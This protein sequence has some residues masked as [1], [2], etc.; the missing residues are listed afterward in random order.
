MTTHSVFGIIW[1]M[2]K[3]T[4]LQRSFVEIYHGMKERN[5]AKAYKQAGSKC[6]GKT[7][8]VEACRTL[9]KPQVRAYLKRLQK[10][11]EERALKTADDIIR[12][13]EKVGFSNIK[14]YFKIE[15]GKVAIKKVSELT[16]AQTAAIAEITQADGSISTFKLYNKLKALKDLGLRFGIFPTKVELSGELTLAQAV[17]KAMKD[18]K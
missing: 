10:K 14:D 8:D 16:E 1:G 13:L 18:E 15:E 11:S 9:K 3:L 2:T 12:E 17:H 6:K 5:Q 7:L 4:P